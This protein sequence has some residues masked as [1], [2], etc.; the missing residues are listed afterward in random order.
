MRDSSKTTL[1]EGHTWVLSADFCAEHEWGA[2]PIQKAFGI[3]APDVRIVRGGAEGFRMKHMPEGGFHFR[4]VP[5]EG[6]ATLYFSAYH[7]YY[8]QRELAEVV[9]KEAAKHPF[10]GPYNPKTRMPG[11]IESG[12][13][14]CWSENGFMIRAKGA[15]NIAELKALHAAFQ[16]CDVGIWV[17]GVGPF[18]GGGLVL[19]ILAK[20]P[21]SIKEQ[22]AADEKA[23][24]SLYAKADATGLI[25]DIQP[26]GSVSPGEMMEDRLH[27]QRD[28]GQPARL[29]VT[30][31][32]DVMFFFN[33]TDYRKFNCGWYTVEELQAFLKG[34]HSLVGKAA[35]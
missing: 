4:Y 23:A 7:R 14:S 30:S 35:S 17:G 34:D 27:P 12:L 18:R 16:R 25:M 10:L 26:Y 15:E 21:S 13:L 24:A 33:P 6:E 5:S 1:I 9:V 2:T 8:P 31:K 3:E 11:T 22:M 29:P 32:Y 20:L 19:S 28:Q